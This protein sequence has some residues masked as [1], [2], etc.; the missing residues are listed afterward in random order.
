LGGRAVESITIEVGHKAD[1]SKVNDIAK[2]LSTEGKK[3]ALLLG[4]PVLLEEGL[5]AASK[6]AEKTGA[7][8]FAEVFPTR[9]ERGAPCGK[10]CLPGRNGFGATI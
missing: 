9:L 6:I 5:V 4:R 10:N 8:L 2:A 3:I 7:K 1:A